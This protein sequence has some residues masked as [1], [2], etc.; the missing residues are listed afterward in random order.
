MFATI[1]TENVNMIRHG[2]MMLIE[3]ISLKKM[4]FL[5]FTIR[6]LRK[7]GVT[8]IKVGSKFYIN[9]KDA[10]SMLSFKN[11]FDFS[12]YDVEEE[13]PVV[14]NE[15]DLPP[16]E[17][18]PAP[19]VITPAPAEPEVPAEPEIEEVPDD[20]DNIDDIDIG[21]DLGA[22]S[23][24]EEEP[25]YDE[26]YKSYADYA[27]ENDGKVCS[28]ISW[29]MSPADFAATIYA[30]QLTMCIY[31]D[32]E[33]SCNPAEYFKAKAA[34]AYKATKSADLQAA[35]Y[36]MWRAGR[37]RELPPVSFLPRLLNRKYWISDFMDKRA[38]GC[39]I[40]S[41][42]AAIP[43]EAPKPKKEAPA[44]APAAAPAEAPKAETTPVRFNSYVLANT[45][46]GNTWCSS[47]IDFVLENGFVAKCYSIQHA[48]C[49]L[50]AQHSAGPE[51]AAMMADSRG[52]SSYMGKGPW[53]GQACSKCITKMH[54]E[55]KSGEE[56][57]LREQEYTRRAAIAAYTDPRNQEMAGMLL[58]TKGKAIMAPAKL[59]GGKKKI[60]S[61]AY[62]R[63]L[64]EIRD[65]I[66]K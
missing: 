48:I 51:F 35:V 31:I 33:M 23:W 11:S 7:S 45:I 20:I 59:P 66:L 37:N 18:V 21:I 1:L 13:V 65:T 57:E 32:A 2:D 47:K 46:K 34:D 17:E 54:K 58:A 36:D 56:W 40:I 27:A 10:D 50:E 3:L 30:K 5:S 19:E 63:L 28:E 25:T 24:N 64:Q 8:P 22:F 61:T 4:N 6:E 52:F 53:D 60:S 9:I 62:T 16:W 14:S 49:V 12:V 15:D 38:P 44:A 26:L 29:D 55:Y 43:V 41:Q 39:R 42:P